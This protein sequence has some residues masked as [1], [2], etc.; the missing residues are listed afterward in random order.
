MPRQLT[1]EEKQKLQGS[2]DFTEKCQ[3]ACRD[4]AAY[5][6]NHT[7]DGL[8]NTQRIKWVKDRLQAKAI[9][10]ND[11]SDSSIALTFV[12]LGSDLA[13]NVGTAPVTIEEMIT[14]IE[15]SMGFLASKYFDLKG[16][17]IN[18]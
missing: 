4:Y 7:G 11:I 12:K 9:V 15:P 10:K 14:A 5:W 1:Q 13:L 8:D 3:W 17:D 18:F 6:V 2:S 16:L